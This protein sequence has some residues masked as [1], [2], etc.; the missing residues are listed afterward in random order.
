MGRHA[1]KTRW[2]G[3]WTRS[4]RHSDEPLFDEMPDAKVAPLPEYEPEPYEGAE[5]SVERTRPFPV[6][7]DPAIDLQPDERHK[8]SR[9]WASAGLAA[10][11][12]LTTFGACSALS[13]DPDTRSQSQAPAAIG[14]SDPDEP[15]EDPPDGPEP[16]PA[17]TTTVTAPGVPVTTTA[18][19][20]RE[21]APTVTV[22]P[23]GPI[24]APAARPVPTVTATR[25]ITQQPYA[26]PQPTVTVTETR[27]R[28]RPRVTVTITIRVPSLFNSGTPSP[29]PEGTP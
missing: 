28:P 8:R 18:S 29:T 3:M 15:S 11:V 19:P 26:E 12:A 5:P 1:G 2:L 6:H 14:P 24:P 13:T 9:L 10:A 25:T 16:E 23:S 7:L 17:S 21:P 20:R 22:S 4:G 27:Y